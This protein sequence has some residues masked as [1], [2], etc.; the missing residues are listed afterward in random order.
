MAS[1]LAHTHASAECSRPSEAV[2][3]DGGDPSRLAAPIA[4]EGSPGS[5]PAG[6]ESARRGAGDNSNN[7]RAGDGG[8]G[9]ADTETES[10]EAE[11]AEVSEGSAAVGGAVLPPQ[12]LGTSGPVPSAVPDKRVAKECEHGRLKGSCKDCKGAQ[13]HRARAR[14]GYVLIFGLSSSHVNGSDPLLLTCA[15]PSTCEHNLPKRSCKECSGS[16]ICSHNRVRNKCRECG[17]AAFCFHQRRKSR[18]RECGGS[19]MCEHGRQKNG[20]KDCGGPGV[21]EHGRRKSQCKECGGSAFCVHQ[22]RKSRC[23]ECG[24]SAICEHGRQKSRCKDCGGPGVCVHGRR[25]SQ[26]KDCGGASICPHDRRRHRCK[27]CMDARLA[28]VGKEHKRASP[29]GVMASPA[30]GLESLQKRQKTV[31]TV[32]AGGES[33]PS[34]AP[35]LC[36]TSSSRLSGDGVEN[37]GAVTSAVDATVT[38]T[39]PLRAHVPVVVVAG[40]QV[41]LVD[42]LSY[43]QPAPPTQANTPGADSCVELSSK[44]RLPPP[45]PPPPPPPPSK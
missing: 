1:P 23:R 38:T 42:A 2:T 12:H 26:C 34:P 25:K 43:L 14:A 24:G 22:R 30:P 21:C 8:A 7:G 20:C 5:M 11:E 45:A 44:T 13:R 41:E 37:V 39:A 32:S 17:S 19:D 10:D 3:A 27:D 6:V 35:A 16:A 31:R 29:A 40:G 15:G 28:Q 36:A 4:L 18:C 9:S 33:R